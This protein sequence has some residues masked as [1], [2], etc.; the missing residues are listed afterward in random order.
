MTPLHLAADKGFEE[1]VKILLEHGSNIDLQNQVL[2]F[3]FSFAGSC[4]D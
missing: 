2:I 4:V 3:S 1:I